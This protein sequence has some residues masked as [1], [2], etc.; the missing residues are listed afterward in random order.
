[1][2]IAEANLSK[3]PVLKL[4][5][6]GELRFLVGKGSLC[7]QS[8]HITKEMQL[9]ELVK[10]SCFLDYWLNEYSG[11]V[12]LCDSEGLQ[13]FC[14]NLFNETVQTIPLNRFE[15]DDSGLFRQEFINLSEG[16]SLRL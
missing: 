9:P 2:K 1:M 11:V 10:E 12:L 7:Y 15:T 6:L 5:N 4:G 13:I 14:L 3:S 8:N 16:A